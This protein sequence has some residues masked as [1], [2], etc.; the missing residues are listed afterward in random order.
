MVYVVFVS[1]GTKLLAW[2]Y[3]IRD[4]R[5]CWAYFCSMF[6]SGALIISVVSSANV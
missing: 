1:F 6:I 5:S 3:V 4:V 2:R